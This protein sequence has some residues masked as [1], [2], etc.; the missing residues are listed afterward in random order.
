MGSGDC[1]VSSKQFIDELNT[2][3]EKQPDDKKQRLA[4][5]EGMIINKLN[6]IKPGQSKR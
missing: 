2:W 3:R 4:D 5:L 1:T 6:T